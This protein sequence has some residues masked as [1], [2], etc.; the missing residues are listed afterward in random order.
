MK[1]FWKYTFPALVAIFVASLFSLCTFH[2]LNLLDLKL[3]D[4]TLVRKPLKRLKE[5][6]HRIVLVA[7][8]DAS[9]AGI[10][11]GWPF[12]RKLYGD[13][14]KNIHAG[15]AAIIGIDVY[16][17]NPSRKSVED[18]YSFVKAMQEAGNVV[19]ASYISIQDKEREVATIMDPI[20]IYI[21]AAAGT[22]FSFGRMEVDSYVRRIKLFHF[23]GQAFYPSFALTLVAKYL[24]ETEINFSPTA[25]TLRLTYKDKSRESNELRNIN[26]PLSA[27]DSLRVTF[28]PQPFTSSISFKDVLSNN[29]HEDL[30]KD[31]IVLI[32]PTAPVL[33]DVYPAPPGHMSGVMIQ[34][35]A[36][37]TI[38]NKEFNYRLRREASNVF[39]F[40]ICLFCSYIFFLA[41]ARISMLVL[42]ISPITISLMS[43]IFASVTDIFFYPMES[44]F[45][46]GILC[47]S[48]TGYQF[49]A[50]R[51][52]R[53]AI[54]NAFQYYLHPDVVNQIIKDPR[55]LKLGGEK[56]VLTVFFSD[57]ANFTSISENRSPESV[58]SL[59]NEYLSEMTDIIF[60][61]GG[62][63]DKFEG[64]AIMAFYGA[65]LPQEDHALLACQAALEMQR[66]LKELRHDWRTKGEPEFYVRM[67]LNTGP[68]LVGNMG[69]HSRMDYTVIGDT[70]NLASRLE[71]VNKVFGT[72]IIISEH[73]N[74]DV[75]GELVTRELGTIR[76]V[77]KTKPVRIYEL[78]GYPDEISDEC[79]EKII[80]FE[81][82]LS[83][84]KQRLWNE[85][86]KAFKKLI[87]SYPNDGPIETYVIRCD[88]FR[89]TPP[90]DNWDGAFTLHYK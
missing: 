64:D 13:V 80:L 50:E 81:Q 18:D 29:F 59:L 35:N 43:F 46:I 88:D 23:D 56:K 89:K 54:K 2:S 47:I 16:F 74:E 6:N 24:A 48:G 39:L 87:K 66:C 71:G 33:H 30:F 49:A 17:T 75:K 90:D 76:V 31:A 78:I 38:L 14:V 22:G 58:V 20:K 72:E 44:I 41:P 70:V 60:D 36:I 83:L 85:A 62:T 79:K 57:I 61:F 7:I 27:G 5:S 52:Q 63:V 67:G 25:R 12:D 42:I 11:Y 37:L 9:I 73:T 40:I 82:A 21:D 10:G 65:P 15:R 28:F 4:Y 84:Y 32:G 19:L 51:K 1:R 34:G 53:V 26:I 55:L 69:S 8:D 86:L 77:G 45:S 68:V 3:H